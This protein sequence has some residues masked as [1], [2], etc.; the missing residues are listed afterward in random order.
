M[1]EP[2]R[3]YE[4][5]ITITTY[6]IAESREDAEQRAEDELNDIFAYEEENRTILAV[7]KSLA[8]VDPTEIDS[9]PFGIRD[10]S[11][12]DRTIAEWAYHLDP[13]EPKGTAP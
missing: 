1:R 7:E 13:P 9:I 11:N 5:T 3:L 4:V 12:E 10:P 6:V 2:R 8:E